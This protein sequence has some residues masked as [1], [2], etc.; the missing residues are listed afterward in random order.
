MTASSAHS[1]FSV[2]PAHQSSPDSSP[3][4]HSQY[5]VCL[6]S[7]LQFIKK[8]SIFRELRASLGFNGSLVCIWVNAAGLLSIRFG[9]SGHLYSVLKDEEAGRVCSL[10]TVCFSCRCPFNPCFLF[11][12]LLLLSITTTPMV[13]YMLYPFNFLTS[14]TQTLAE[15]WCQLDFTQEPRF[16]WTYLM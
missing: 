2:S 9:V 1:W 16:L 13:L 3:K 7:F 6:F 14:L 5:L 12:F 11:S 10:G 8:I 4:P 15:W